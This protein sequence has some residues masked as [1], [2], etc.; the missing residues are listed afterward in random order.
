MIKLWDPAKGVETK[1]L[2]GHTDMVWGLAFA[3]KGFAL[4]SASWDKTDPD[5]GRHRREPLALA[6]AYPGRDGACL[7][8]GGRLLVSGGQDQTVKLWEAATA[9]N[10][11]LER[12]VQRPSEQG[13]FADLLPDGRTLATGGGD[14][15]LR[16]WDTAD[17]AK[18]PRELQAGDPLQSAAFSPDGK[19][20]VA[21]HVILPEQAHG[22]GSF[23]RARRRS[24]AMATAASSARWPSHPT[25]RPWSRAA[26]TRALHRLEHGDVGD[27]AYGPGAGPIRVL[28]GVRA[29]WQD[30]GRRDDSLSGRRKWTHGARCGDL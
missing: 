24:R 7:R 25:A 27:R 28:G 3:P 12:E 23:G 29:R 21:G 1:T 11:V 15:V 9:A 16:L 4:A 17:P 18:A 5:L 26:P 8:P 30:A 19:T 20:L 10:V 2:S 22:L 6:G 13:L 14:Q